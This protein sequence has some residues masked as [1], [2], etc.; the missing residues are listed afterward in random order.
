MSQLAARIVSQRVLSQS[1][2]P[3]CADEMADDLKIGVDT[4]WAV[5]VTGTM[6]QRDDEITVEKMCRLYQWI[7]EF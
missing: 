3:C 7:F 5:A 4:T 1:G 2:H 6:S